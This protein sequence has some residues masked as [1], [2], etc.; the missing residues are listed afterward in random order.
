MK[1]IQDGLMLV[2]GKVAVKGLGLWATETLFK[3]PG[4]MSGGGVQAW[5][6]YASYLGI[7]IV[8]D[9]VLRS[10]KMTRY[11]RPLWTAVVFTM[12]HDAANDWWGVNQEVGSIGRAALSGGRPGGRLRD[13]YTARAH[14][15]AGRPRLGDWITKERLNTP[16]PA[17]IPEPNFSGGFAA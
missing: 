4:A 13:H 14:Q 11:A 6:K 15:L 10:M 12:A 5:Q 3:I 7:G 2:A 16:F 1:G 9:V 17:A 8:G